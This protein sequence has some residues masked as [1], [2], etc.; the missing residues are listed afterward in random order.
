MAVMPV[1]EVRAATQYTNLIPTKD[2]NDAAVAQAVPVSE[3]A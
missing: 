2:D 3:R 1:M